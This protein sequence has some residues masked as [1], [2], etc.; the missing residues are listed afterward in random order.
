MTENDAAL[1]GQIARR[2]WIV[3]G[4]LVLGSLFFRSADVTTGILAG[5]LIAILGFTWMQRSLGR[6][7]KN[8]GRGAI[9]KY[10]FTYFLRLATIG[11]LI[12]AVLVYA[13]VHPIG[14]IVGL[15]V[16]VVN[17]FWVTFRRLT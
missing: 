9:A 15:S 1:V 5:G 13:H 3:L 7:M 8:P 12:W 4:L 10:K 11:L 16:I 14:L 2:N 17:L 6:V